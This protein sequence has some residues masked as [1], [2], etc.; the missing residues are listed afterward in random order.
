[1]SRESI[2]RLSNRLR[3]FQAKVNLF[4]EA[5][6]LYHLATVEEHWESK[7]ECLKS[8]R[9]ILHSMVTFCNGEPIIESR[10]DFG[11]NYDAYGRYCYL[12]RLE[13][14]RGV[15][16]FDATKIDFYNELKDEFLARSYQLVNKLEVINASV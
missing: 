7:M 10:P 11:D 13:L 2:S 8:M 12:L 1:M 3:I 5:F 14:A 9:S 15:A 6:E 4:Y 16:K